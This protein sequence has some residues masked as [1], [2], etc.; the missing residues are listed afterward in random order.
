VSGLA[1]GVIGDFDGARPTHAATNAALG[2]AAQALGIALETRWLPTAALDPL[3]PAELDPLAGFLVAPGS[4]VRSLTGALS[5][6]GFAREQGR[7]L[8]GTCAGFQ[9]VVLEL[10]R[11][12]LGRAE[13]QHAEYAPGAADLAIEPLAC[14]LAGEQAAVSLAP[15]SRAAASY[16]AESVREEYRCSYG[17]ASSY[18]APLARAGLRVSG[19]DARGEPRVVELDGAPFYVATL[20]VPQLASAPEL[21]HPLFRAFLAA[22]AEGAR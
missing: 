16:G 11:R 15:G 4:P 2:H 3:R 18:E 20:Y 22:C 10:A 6:I 13:A 1:I 17:L 8:L 5:A 7:P 21:P 9:H 19:R 12:V 14:S